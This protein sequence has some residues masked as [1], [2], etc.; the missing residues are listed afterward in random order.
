MKV[1]PIDRV[2]PMDYAKQVGGI[3]IRTYLA[4]RAMQGIL[5]ADPMSRASAVSVALAAVECANALIAEL[6]READG[7]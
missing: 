3:E 7:K 5:A 6:N 4:A 1:N 2:F